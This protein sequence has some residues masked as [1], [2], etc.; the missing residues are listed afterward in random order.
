MWRIVKYT[1]QIIGYSSAAVS[2]LLFGG[3]ALL[4]LTDANAGGLGGFVKYL[5][6]SS[7]FLSSVLIASACRPEDVSAV[8]MYNTVP[9]PFWQIITKHVIINWLAISLTAVFVTLIT[10]A[11]T[12]DV[13]HLVLLLLGVVNVASNSLLFGGLALWGTV[14][15]RDSRKGQ[16]LGLFV[17]VLS[18]L[19]SLP[20]FINPAV[21]PYRV[22]DGLNFPIIWWASRF[23][24]IVL[25]VLVCVHSLYLARD[26]DRLIVGKQPQSTQLV[27]VHKFGVWKKWKDFISPSGALLAPPSKF[28]GLVTY[29]ALLTITDGVIPILV[30]VMCVMSTCILPLFDVVHSGFEGLLL[31]QAESPTFSIYF[32]FPLLPAFLVNRIPHDRQDLLDQLLLTT[33]SPREYLIG[34]AVGAC[35]ATSGAF[36]LGNLLPLLLLTIAAL[37][38]SS[39]IMLCYLGILTLGVVPALVY[40]SVISVLV[41]GLVRSRHP[42]LVGGVIAVGYIVLLIATHNSVVGN[43]L[44]PTGAMASETLLAWLRQQMSIIYSSVEPIRTVVP[45]F[46]LFFPILSGILQIGL[47]WFIVGRIFEKEITKA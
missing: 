9:Y 31:S 6:I 22:V 19:V 35:V 38:G 29:E 7:A 45:P 12:G 42:T 24:Y 41:G 43:I 10:V 2:F 3:A 37:F 16:L 13:Y 36:L 14:F 47:V 39:H 4:A 46:Y 28:L 26:T 20:E 33:I 21:H 25:G 30:L 17:F 11:V 18:L 8:E 44:F 1:I 27:P 23:G 15:G 34:K 40:I 32:L 5:A